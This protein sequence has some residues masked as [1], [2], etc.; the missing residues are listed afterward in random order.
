VIKASNYKAS[1]K[2]LIM[3]EKAVKELDEKIRNVVNCTEESI[4][5]KYHLP[6]AC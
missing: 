1:K 2:C 6:A 4:I 5:S 3:M